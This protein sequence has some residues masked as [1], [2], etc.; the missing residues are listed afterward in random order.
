M[1]IHWSKIV[2]TSY[3]EYVKSVNCTV[4]CAVHIYSIYSKWLVLE[5]WDIYMV[6]VFQLVGFTLILASLKLN[7]FKIGLSMAHRQHIH[8][9]VQ[10]IIKWLNQTKFL[11]NLAWQNFYIFE[12]VRLQI[13]IV[14]PTLSYYTKSLNNFFFYF[15]R[16]ENLDGKYKNLSNMI[17][18]SL[19]NNWS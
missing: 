7:W 16:P 11:C 1:A 3:S 9:N 4:Q 19:V 13:I 17:N 14:I 2:P 5:W 15:F 18:N 6:L 10:Y 12:S 8:K